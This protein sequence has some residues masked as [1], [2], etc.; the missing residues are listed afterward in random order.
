[1]KPAPF[2]YACPGT[3]EDALALLA[4]GGE[5]AKV[6]AG[7][8]SLLPAMNL[9]LARP[10]LL[11]D[12]G[13]V[14]GLDRVE[15]GDDAVAIGATA[16]HRTLELDR[17][18]P[19]ALGH[20]LRDAG[21][22]IGHVPIRMRGTFGGSL[23]HADPASE[24]PLVAL[25]ADAR[26]EARS[27]RGHRTIPA[28]EFFVSVFTTALAPD[29]VLARA[30]LPLPSPAARAGFAELS[31][32]AGDFALVACAAL[33]DHSGDAAPVAR[34]ALGGVADRP[35]RSAAAEAV[36]HEL[37]AGPATSHT[38]AAAA[39]AAGAAAAAEVEPR[40]DLHANAD[41]RRALVAAMVRRAVTDAWSRG[42]PERAGVAA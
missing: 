5:D 22:L 39:R 16:R 13:R 2:D 33:V 34:V 38:V 24:W 14:P 8:Q 20:L 15:V 4:D 18:V 9:R 41:T 26:L 21:G 19:G 25:A 40:G 10:S 32:R 36:L 35:V 23:A 12:I 1:V 37:A 3:L 31:R 30:V 11:V 6:L 7:G 42:G 29:E 27:V 28:P 17:T